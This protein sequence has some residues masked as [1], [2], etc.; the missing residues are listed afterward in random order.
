MESEYDVFLSHVAEDFGTVEEVA[1]A[2]EKKG[3]ATWYYERDNE[4]GHNW[5]TT[6]GEVIPRCRAIV[7]VV[8]AESLRNGHQIDTEVFLAFEGHKRFFPLLLDV[9]F[10]EFKRQQPTW[11][12]A[13]VGAVAVTLP[14]DGVSAAM[15]KLLKGLKSAGIEPQ[16]PA[17]QPADDA[18]QRLTKIRK[19]LNDPD[20]RASAEQAIR[21]LLAADPASPQAYRLLG[22]FY[23]RSFRGA[24]AVEAFE[25]ATE[26]DGTSALAH[27]DL[28]LAYRQE[29]RDADTVVSLK[30][31]L[32]LGIDQSRQRLAMTLLSQLEPGEQG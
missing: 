5:L 10:D 12:V 21:D 29:G 2:L 18:E 16:K 27:W 19:L 9:E 28:A 24:E 17:G 4:A 31:A 26:L 23:N 30:R 20:K 6:I 3:Y 7:I 13:I 8:S 11:H 25:K 14:A 32:E 22:E 1:Y 15:P